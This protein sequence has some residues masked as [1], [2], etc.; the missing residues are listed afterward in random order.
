[1]IKDIRNCYRGGNVLFSRHARDEM[2]NEEFGR[3]LEKEVQAS[4]LNGKVIESYI[5]DDPYPSCLI[6]GRAENNR[7]LHV[8]CAYSKEDNMVIVITV[9]EPD[10]QKWINFERRKS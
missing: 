7:P 4:I 3:I 10:P 6:Y 9:Y 1:M 8:V 2:E 5:D